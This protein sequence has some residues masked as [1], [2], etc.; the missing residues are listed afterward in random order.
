MRYSCSNFT[1]GYV[2]ERYLDSILKALRLES[3]P[4]VEY[5]HPTAAQNA[6]WVL[7]NSAQDRSIKKRDSTSMATPSQLCIPSFPLKNNQN[8]TLGELFIILLSKSISSSQYILPS[9][10]LKDQNEPHKHK[11]HHKPHNFQ[12]HMGFAFI[13]EILFPP[14]KHS[15]TTPSWVRR[16]SFQISGHV[17]EIC[18]VEVRHII[19]WWVDVLV[20]GVGGSR[21]WHLLHSVLLHVEKS[22]D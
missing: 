20:A 1:L 3:L 7:T 9:D 14:S 10:S 17:S 13:L 11:E 8:R 2:I 18:A 4:A 6:T 22:H 5:L 15:P 19:W 21:G 12:H 16:R